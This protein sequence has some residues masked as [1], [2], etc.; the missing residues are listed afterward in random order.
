MP[1]ASRLGKY[2][3][4]HA[5]QCQLIHHARSRDLSHAVLLAQAVPE[6]TVK[7][8]LVLDRAG[9]AAL[10]VPFQ[11]KPNIDALNSFS[12]RDFQLIDDEQAGRLFTDC[13]HGHVPVLGQAYDL[14]L[15]V[16]EAVFS[17][18]E[19]FASSGCA[20]TL[21]RLSQG[22]V[23]AVLRDA[24][25]GLFSERLAPAESVL[26]A[27]KEYSLDDIA[28][29]L[30]KLYRLPPMPETSV[31]IMHLTSN[32]ES[33]LD[34][35]V[36]LVERDPSL[37][38]QILRYARSALFNYRGQ[39][40]CVRDAINVVLGFD[41]VAK[42]AMGI[43]SAQA[44]RVPSHG[45]L[46]LGNFWKHALHCAVL[47]EALATMA[48]PDLNL[49]ARESY[50]SG[51]LHNFGLL[52]IGQL[53][54]PEFRM[55]NKLRESDPERSMAEIEKQVFGMGSAQEFIALGHG[56]LGAILLKL[57]G[58]PESCVKSAAMHQNEYYDGEHAEQVAV[59]CL[60]NHL[61]AMHGVGD[62]PASIDPEP[63]FELLGIDPDSAYRLAEV[64]VDQGQELD[65]MVSDLVA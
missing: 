42:L 64:T 21:L 7:T 17:W 54:P 12:S 20:N 49:D 30:N 62:E 2:I 6:L 24:N 19:V 56:S 27:D 25:V 18:E 38:A 15:Y 51:L 46:G 34:E 8:H 28:R 35:L 50:L 57:W 39:L 14:P 16:D 23:R 53:F 1:I 3:H 55:M 31:R 43:S 60:A 13:D 65:G 59:V 32:P 22:S 47:C 9:P 37:S 45:A 4:A 41:R 63:L 48:K 36:M 11:A 58:L 29:K 26:C 10:I 33:S 40:H 5:V 61:L 52:L 44:F